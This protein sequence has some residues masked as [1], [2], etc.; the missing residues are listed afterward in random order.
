[1][2][3]LSHNEYEQARE[4]ACNVYDECIADGMDGDN[5]IYAYEEAYADAVKLLI[6][7]RESARA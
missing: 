7:A 2:A 4:I 1:M 5:A 3:Q 6:R